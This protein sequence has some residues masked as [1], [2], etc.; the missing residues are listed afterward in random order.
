M[1]SYASSSF[2][3]SLP[4]IGEILLKRRNP[5]KDCKRLLIPR[6]KYLRK[7]KPHSRSLTGLTV[8]LEIFQKMQGSADAKSFKLHSKARTDMLTRP[9]AFHQ[10][11]EI[12]IVA[13]E[14][15]IQ[16]EAYYTEEGMYVFEGNQKQW[17]KYPAE[18]VSF[19][20]SSSPQHNLA[21]ELRKAATL[22]ENS[23]LIKENAEVYLISLTTNRPENS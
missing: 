21:G 14:K 7:Q 3:C 20:L 22:I 23:L 12:N 8:D 10:K 16:T 11:S 13:T 4:A 18:Q 5:G 17:A 15:S 1:E 6:N 19:G 9:I 2:F